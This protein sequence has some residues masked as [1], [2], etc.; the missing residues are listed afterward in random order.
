M[1][2]KIEVVFDE[3]D[4]SIVGTDFDFDFWMDLEKRSRRRDQ[5]QG[6]KSS[7]ATDAQQPGR[8]GSSGR[9]EG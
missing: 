8:L 4:I 1:D 5:M 6:C 7:W 3:I 2:G 9:C